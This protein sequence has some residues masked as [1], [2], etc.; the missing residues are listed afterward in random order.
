[1]KQNVLKNMVGGQEWRQKRDAEYCS[2]EYSKDDMSSV[3]NL[4]FVTHVKI[5]NS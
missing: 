4:N 5:I 2:A 3:I 1:M